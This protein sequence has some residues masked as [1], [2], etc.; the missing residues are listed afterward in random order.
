MPV[1]HTLP[2]IKV[3]YLRLRPAYCALSGSVFY[4]YAVYKHPVKG[5][6]ARF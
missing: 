5:P 3:D 1:G 2:V 4:G 6:V